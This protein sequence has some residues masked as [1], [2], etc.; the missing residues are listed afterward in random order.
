[1]NLNSTGGSARVVAESETM[2]TICLSAPAPAPCPDRSRGGTRPKTAAVTSTQRDSF[3]DVLRTLDRAILQSKATARDRLKTVAKPSSPP[4]TAAAAAQPQ[5]TPSPPPPPAPPT[6]PPPPPPAPSQAAAEAAVETMLGRH[7]A[8]MS[9][10]ALDSR[11]R[12]KR[13][14]SAAAR[15]WK[16]NDLAKENR[17]EKGCALDLDGFRVLG[18]LGHTC[19]AVLG[20]ARDARDVLRMEYQR[21][22]HP[23]G[24]AAPLRA[25]VLTALY[26]ITG[27]TLRAAVSSL[28][29]SLNSLIGCTNLSAPVDSWRQLTTLIWQ[30]LSV[31]LDACGSSVDAE[32]ADA[33]V[34]GFRAAG[35]QATVARSPTAAPALYLG[36]A[37]SS[38]GRCLSMAPPPLPPSPPTSPGPQ[39]GAEEAAAAG[40]APAARRPC[41]KACAA[42]AGR[43]RQA[44]LQRRRRASV[45]A[46]PRDR[47]KEALLAQWRQSGLNIP[48]CAFV[49]AAPGGGG[50]G[51]GNRG[52]GL[53][54]DTTSLNPRLGAVGSFEA[55]V[56][57]VPQPQP[58][59]SPSPPSSPPAQNAKAVAGVPEA[60]PPQQEG[61]DTVLP[62][63]SSSSSSPP[64]APS[65][66]AAA[67][68]TAAASGGGKAAA[69][70]IGACASGAS[71]PER[72]A[73]LRRKRTLVYRAF[74]VREKEAFILFARTELGLHVECAVCTMR[75][76]AARVSL[77]RLEGRR[78]EWAE[79]AQDDVQRRERRCVLRRA[80]LLKQR[81]RN[82]E[83]VRFLDL[84]RF[85][86]VKEPPVEATRG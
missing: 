84:G 30:E 52:G 40:A 17:W 46:E 62:I 75:A 21:C 38:L 44:R 33:R 27:S 49:A 74:T 45:L 16:G 86:C 19:A 66:E 55:V 26:A 54:P 85:A 67:A 71:L 39:V 6:P 63:P 57:P 64:P 37:P 4:P 3:A 61:A 79:R 82:L 83:K 15:L 78:G 42:R 76:I 59:P 22:V 23:T 13:Y 32:E 56:T 77:R 28:S 20:D 31:P 34:Q 18:S 69:Q 73:H 80:E 53:T 24:A 65:T 12:E 43:E 36:P 47:R 11:E 41:Q 8:A 70:V 60:H 35:L 7:D 5:A 2:K 25:D 10:T 51:G 68:T 58:P 14:R 50:S 9:R 81:W 29:S 1:M 48:R 72:V